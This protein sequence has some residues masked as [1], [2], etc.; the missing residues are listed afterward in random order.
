MKIAYLISAHTD[1]THLARLVQALDVE[2]VTDFFVH[3]D[4]KVDIAPFMRALPPVEKHVTYCKTRIYSIWGGYSQCLYQRE[5]IDTCKN[6]GTAYDRVFFLT[7]QDYPLWL[8]ERII[9]ELAS[10]PDTQYITGMDISTCDDPPKIKD[11]LVLYHFFRD[12]P[13]PYS[14][15]ISRGSRIIMRLLPIRRK[16]YIVDKGVKKHVFQASSY[17]CLTWPLIEHISEQFRNKTLANYFKYTFAPD[18]LFL[19]TIVFN[20]PYAGQATLHKGGYPGLK[21]LTQLHYIEYNKAIKV[22]T[23]EDFDL[24]MSTGKM[25]A[26]KLVTGTSDALMDMIDKARQ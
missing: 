5:L 4:K 22:F 25:F 26:R 12:L 17:C 13:V 9:K 18:E 19:P 14:L 20:S 1:P 11:K 2:G 8:N 7:G 10:H 23:E 24:L 16:P 6:S 15:K 21:G 3:V